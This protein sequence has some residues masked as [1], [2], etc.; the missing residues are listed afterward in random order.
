MPVGELNLPREGKISRR[1]S[2]HKGDVSGV[3]FGDDQGDNGYF[4]NNEYSY[5]MN[6]VI[7]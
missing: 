1:Q 5:I 2:A 3:D 7:Q 4:E 6:I